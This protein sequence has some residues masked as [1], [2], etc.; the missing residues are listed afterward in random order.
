MYKDVVNDKYFVMYTGVEGYFSSP[1]HTT[2]VFQKPLKQYI[3]IR[4]SPF[5]RQTNAQKQFSDKDENPTIFFTQT[6]CV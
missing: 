4:L 6:V 5:S 1:F 2:I 3:E